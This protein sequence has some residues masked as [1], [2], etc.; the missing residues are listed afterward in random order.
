MTEDQL[1]FIATRIMDRV[2]RDGNGMQ[3]TALVEEL[4][5]GLAIVQA[6]QPAPIQHAPLVGESQYLADQLRQSKNSLNSAVAGPRE[7]ALASDGRL[8]Y[9]FTNGA[10]LPVAIS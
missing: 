7:G 9:R 5:A 6:H 1:T 2:E 8:V 3:L 10:W 4:R